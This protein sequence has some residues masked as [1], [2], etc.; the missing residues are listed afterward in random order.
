MVLHDGGPVGL[1]GVESVEE[2]LLNPA[3]GTAP[4]S[5][6]VALFGYGV[7]RRR[8]RGGQTYFVTWPSL[9]KIELIWDRRS[10]SSVAA[11]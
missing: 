3:A 9:I 6:Q 2:V 7:E 8:D 4:V 1:V 10:G 5:F 11:V